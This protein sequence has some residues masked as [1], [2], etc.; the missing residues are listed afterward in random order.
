MRGFYDDYK[1]KQSKDENA[2]RPTVIRRNFGTAFF[3]FLAKF[4][5][6]II[7]IIVITLS[8]IGFTVLINGNL[9]DM[10]FELIKNIL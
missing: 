8:S 2:D 6:V 3:E 4:F 1:S 7:H 5:T 10:L 9:R